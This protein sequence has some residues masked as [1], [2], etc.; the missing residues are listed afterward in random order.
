MTLRTL[1]TSDDGTTLP[2]SGRSAAVSVFR[3]GF[4][5]VELLIVLTIIGIV[6]A[7]T[8]PSFVNSMK[9]NQLRAGVR[10]LVTATRY[11]RSMS[12]L[13]GGDMAIIFHLDRETYSICNAAGGRQEVALGAR[14]GAAAS[15]LTDEV[16]AEGAEQTNRIVF[17]DGRAFLDKPELS[18]ELRGVDI[19]SV[20][21]K[22]SGSE[23]VS[24][25]CTI[26]F[27]S[28]G[29]CEPFTV[30]M[31]DDAGRGAIIEVDALASCKTS[32]WSGQ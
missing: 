17:A 7:I 11:A 4:T 24:G 3:R 22:S 2:R 28:N 30:T 10:S 21:L 9:G 13:R 16:S 14:E 1:P 5:L 8:L 29:R 20:V 12:I 32:S 26:V 23:I 27:G 25:E 31:K 18:G 19:V 6:A 15:N